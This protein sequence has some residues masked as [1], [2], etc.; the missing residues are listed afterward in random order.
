MF[1][2][3]FSTIVL[4]SFL[5]GIAAAP[6][7]THLMPKGDP[8][9][10]PIKVGDRLVH[11]LAG[12]E[13]I[14]VVTKSEKID[15][16][17]RVTLDITDTSTNSNY[18]QIS[19]VTARGVEVIEYA[20]Q[21]RD[22]SIWWVKLPHGAKNEWS[23]TWGGG[24]TFDFATKGWEM[25]EVPAGRLKAIKVE[26]AESQNGTVLG[27]TTYWYSPGLGCIKVTGRSPARVLKSFTPG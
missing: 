15:G 23:S 22:P 16:G 27:T 20:G 9:C 25:V 1:R 8:V 2:A 4:L 5:A 21:K 19:N 7:P 13:F 11:E 24:L 12:G 14:Q 10:Y 17:H 18:T 3:A 6:V 26:R